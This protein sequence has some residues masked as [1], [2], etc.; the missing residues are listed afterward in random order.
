MAV[1][2]IEYIKLA[3]SVCVSAICACVSCAI[4]VKLTVVADGTGGQ[5]LVGLMLPV[6]TFA[7]SYLPISAHA[8]GLPAAAPILFCF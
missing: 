8:R 3:M 2:D 4:G 7:E 1:L 6:L 5:V